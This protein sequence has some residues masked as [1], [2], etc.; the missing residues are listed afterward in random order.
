M[1]QLTVSIEI[2]D[3]I[4]TTGAKPTYDEKAKVN[5]ITYGRDNWISYDDA[6]TFKDKINFANERGLS[7]LMIWAIDLDDSK[8]SALSALTGGGRFGSDDN[9]IVG[10]SRTP[11]FREGYS[12]DDSSQCRVTKCGEKCSSSETAVGRSQSDFGKGT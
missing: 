10:S 1:S 9:F 6:K 12:S 11:D 7:G 8:G 3:I 4:K 2:M 5:Y